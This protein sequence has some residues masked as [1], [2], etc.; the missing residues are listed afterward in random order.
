MNAITTSR[1]HTGIPA[2]L[3]DTIHPARLFNIGHAVR[4]QEAIE[5]S[6][7]QDSQSNSGAEQKRSVSFSRV[8][9]VIIPG[10]ERDEVRH[11]LFHFFQNRPKDAPSNCNNADVDQVKEKNEQRQEEVGE[12]EGHD[13]RR[14]GGSRGGT[15]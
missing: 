6:K 12:T 2:I 5:I 11:H 13:W 7:E 10:D 3:K 8:C 4:E 9:E 1:V 15:D 14:A